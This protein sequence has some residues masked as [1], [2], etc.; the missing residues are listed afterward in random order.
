MGM[1]MRPH[2]AVESLNG[3]RE[4]ADIRSQPGKYDILDLARLPMAIMEGVEQIVCYVN[5]ALC[6]LTGK[7]REDMVGK[8]FVEI[9]PDGDKCLLLLDQ[10]YR[11]GKAESHTEQEDVG[12]H[13]LSWSYEI[14]PVR[15]GLT[16]DDSPAGV[17]IQMT[18]TTPFHRRATA[19]NEALMISAV[20]LHELMEAEETLNAKLQ[21]EIKE[22]KQAQDALLRSEMLASAGRMAASIAHEINNP[23]AA[24]MNTLFLIRTTADVPKSAL[25]YLGIADGE[26]MRIA[27][28]TRQTL[29]F[30]REF[31][32]ATS[33][34][35]SALM[36]SVV[37]LLQTKIRTSGAT[38]EQQCDDQLQVMGVAGELR[39][40]LANL[41][42]N[43]LD[44]VGENGIVKLRGS[45]VRSST[46]GSHCIRMTVADNGRG[47]GTD[48]MGQIFDPF[49][50]TRGSI[51]TGLGLWVCK[52]LV[53]KNGGSI[54][55]HS[56]TDGKLRGTTF[57]VVLPGEAA[58]PEATA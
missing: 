51:G 11:T 3:N 26:L 7:D 8:P 34:S 17:I 53:E 15:A 23:L 24:V 10:V 25:E 46:T 36:D 13:S 20:R 54:Q 16:E 27:H 37:D 1:R 49:Y 55:V 32:A 42:A 2:T 47:I 18:E 56:S 5:P 9:L 12:L 44:A 48:V 57:S 19:M 31:S 14:W 35:V 4:E 43:S 45:V 22:R 38:I 29:G 50:T 33:N 30:Y 58:I 28:I 6:S 21:A 39:Q 40:L 52:Q 41:L